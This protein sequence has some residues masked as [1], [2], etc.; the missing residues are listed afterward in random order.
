MSPESVAGRPSPA[1][2]RSGIERPG[3]CC[4]MAPNWRAPPSALRSETESSLLPPRRPRGQMHPVGTRREREGVGRCAFAGGGV[5]SFRSPE[6]SRQGAP[7]RRAK[8][9]KS[10]RRQLRRKEHSLGKGEVVSSILT[11]STTKKP[12]KSRLFERS[13]KNRLAGSCRTER[14]ATRR[15][16][17]NPPQAFGRCSC[18]QMHP[19]G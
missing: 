19:E 6:L 17:P 7:A 9:T 18:S 1:A 13:Q 12:N 16:A 15:N 10:K 11:G 4:R 14:E 5:Q 3:C 2:F 8:R